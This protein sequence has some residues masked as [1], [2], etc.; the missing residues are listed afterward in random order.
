MRNLAISDIHGCFQTFR[1]LVEDQIDLQKEDHLYI[2]GDL[3]D[4][5]PDSKG[6]IDY[7]L[8]LQRKGYQLS[9]LRGNHETMM[10]NSFGTLSHRFMWLR[11]GGIQTVE[12][13][14]IENLEMIPDDIITFAQDLEYYFEIDDYIL[15]HAGLDFKGA[16]DPLANTTA[17]QWI[18]DWY[19][20]IDYNW[21]GKRKIIHG[22][23]P[24]KKDQIQMM[25]DTIGEVGVLNIDCGAYKVHKKGKGYLCAFDMTNSKLYFQENVDNMSAWLNTVT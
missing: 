21:L 6:V 10:L 22:H 20:D 16:G 9:C 1:K 7:I 14:N 24:K 23:T 25:F 12:S 18:R 13:F 3:I 2:L 5:G 8:K 15:V 11:N 19:D 17:M 4:R